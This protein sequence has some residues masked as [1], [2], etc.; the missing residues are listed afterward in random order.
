MNFSDLTI[1]EKRTEQFLHSL[2]AQVLILLLSISMRPTPPDSP[3]VRSWGT[4]FSL[5]D[6]LHLAYLSSSSFHADRTAFFLR[7]S[8]TP[9][10]KCAIFL[11]PFVS[12]LIL[13]C[14]H[15]LVIVENVIINMR[16]HMS[17]QHRDLISLG[18]VIFSS[19]Q[20]RDCWIIQDN[21]IFN[22]WGICQQLFKIIAQ[23]YIPYEF[24]HHIQNFLFITSLSLVFIWGE[25]SQYFGG[26]DLLSCGCLCWV[27]FLHRCWTFLCFLL[28]NVHSSCLFIF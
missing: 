19:T 9:L 12:W 20:Y 24:F 16:M 14:S 15:F 1:T 18:Y 26:F 4:C 7:L 27:F 8:N 28:R 13:H 11:S 17:G 21:S 10:C 5:P 6:R 3:W 2:S 22:F 23:M 25:V